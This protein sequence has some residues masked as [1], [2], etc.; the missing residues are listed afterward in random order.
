MATSAKEEAKMYHRQVRK[1]TLLFAGPALA[2]VLADPLMSVVDATCVGRMCSTLQLASLGPSLTVFN[3]ANYFFYFLNAATAVLVTQSLAC[4]DE[5]GAADTLAAAVFL[6]VV[7]GIAASAL[8][9]GLAPML[10]A[11][12]GCVAELIPA[13]VLYLRV[14]AIGQPIV[15]SSMVI[16]ASLLAQ[17]DVLT[18][19]QVVLASCALN[20]VCDILWVPMLG[21]VGAAWATLLSQ[22]V[23]LPLMLWLAA[24]RGRL[25]VRLRFARIAELRTFFSTAAPLFFFEVGM[26]T[27]Y[28]LI[29]SLSTQFTVAAA[30]AFQ[31]LW[32]P[33]QVLCFMTYPLKQ[34][35][36][37][38]ASAPT[39]HARPPARLTPDATTSQ[40]YQ[41]P[42]S[43]LRAAHGR[44]SCPASS[45]LTRRRALMPPHKATATAR[46]APPPAKSRAPRWAGSPSPRSC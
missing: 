17:L 15:L 1:E 39:I 31:A 29:Q 11:S 8:L 10:V 34:A 27:C 45:R 20:V 36:Q 5:A 12:T 33:L 35:A 25:P 13:A 16:Q 19:L 46:R 14:R 43:L 2:T 22:A 4:S 26:S 37:V 42:L 30:A 32:S 3:F 38:R 6:A 21:A 23:A 18:P 24:R 9:I 7:C 44:S 28:A 40:T 41:R